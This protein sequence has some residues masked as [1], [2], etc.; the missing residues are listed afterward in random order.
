MCIDGLGNDFTYDSWTV[1][2]VHFD[3]S[4]IIT[5]PDLIAI[6]QPPNP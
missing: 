1:E 5:D 3:N 2:L 6:I 4:L